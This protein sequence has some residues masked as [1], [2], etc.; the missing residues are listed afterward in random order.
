M[1]FGGD[2]LRF[3]EA[4]DGG[5]LGAAMPEEQ[6]SAVDRYIRESLL[7]AD[8]ALEAAQAAAAAAG[9]PEIQVTANQGKLL[10]LHARMC[11]AR[12]ILELGTLAGYSTIWLARGLPPGGRLVTLEAD[13]A[14]AAVARENFARAGLDG[15]VELVV[16][17]ALETLP[18]LAAREPFEPYDLIF[19]DADKDNY[20]AYLE[21]CLKL[22]R[23][24]TVIIADNVVRNGAVLDPA[25]TDGRVQGVRRLYEMA[26]REARLSAT[27]L[28]TVGEKGYDGFMVAIVN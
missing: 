15:V 14:H 23:R 24:G 21:W 7:P 4:G 3:R 19:I 25:S 27:A 13:P 2:F 12:R 16:G 20:P 18:G 9:L 11:G 28:Q 6:W 26:G 1:F 22:A 17:P 5:I 8:P 10:Q